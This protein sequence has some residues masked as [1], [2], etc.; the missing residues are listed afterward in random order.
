MKSSF[1]TLAAVLLAAP[2]VLTPSSAEAGTLRV[3][4]KG[5]MPAI[6][7]V[8]G[9][10]KG[11]IKKKKPLEMEV[12]DGPHEV[13]VAIETGGTVTRCQGLVDVSGTTTVDIS[14]MGGCTNLR[15]G[16]GPP[17]QS[18]FRGSSI[19]FNITGVDAWVQV[20]GSQPLALPSMPF[21]LNLEPGTHTI[22]LWNDNF[23]TSVYDQ[24]TVTL[25]A[26]ERLAVTCTPGGCLGFDAPPQ[27]IEVYTVP[28]VVIQAPPVAPASGGLGISIN[29]PGVSIEAGVGADGSLLGAGVSVDGAG[30]GGL[31]VGAGANGAAVVVDG[32][33]QSKSNGGSASSC[34]INGAYYTCPDADAVYK[35][36]GAFM[37]CMANCGMMDM[38]CPTQ[39][40]ESHPFDPSRCSR[41]PAS[42]AT[43]E[44]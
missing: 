33:G 10:S 9:I 12:A 14:D 42:D 19:D 22:V 18:V 40:M 28:G 44:Q 1:P 7:W 38:E 24:G 25:R 13:W 37:A 27:I 16:F 8:D 11:K 34:C 5:M 6:V 23:Q 15:R 41:A 29:V 32:G 36:S 43:C 20:D 21:L 35:C 39:C 26:G 2:F 30:F 4:K 3:Q 17:E 31:A